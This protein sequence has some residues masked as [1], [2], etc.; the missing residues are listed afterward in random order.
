[1]RAPR[2][3]SPPQRPPVVSVLENVFFWQNSV[4]IFVANVNVCEHFKFGALQT[5]VNIV[6][7]EKLH[8][9]YLYLFMK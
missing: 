6:Y 4:N 8:N 1:M 7:L 2:D 9:D 3:G 5:S